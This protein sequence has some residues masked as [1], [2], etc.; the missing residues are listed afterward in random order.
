MKYTKAYFYQYGNQYPNQVDYDTNTNPYEILQEG[1]SIYLNIPFKVKNVHIKN[2]TYTNGKNAGEGNPNVSNY[3]TYTSEM[4]GGKPVGMV[5]RDSQFS[6]ST[7]QDIEHTFQ[8][9]PLING[10]YRFNFFGNDGSNEFYNGTNIY[11]PFYYEIELVPPFPDIYHYWF[12]SFSITIEFNDE[13]EI[14]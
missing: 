9:P 3:I 12:D 13:N 14:F 4:I 6:M 2:I 11:Y 5:H 8:I 10:Y 1:A 7:K